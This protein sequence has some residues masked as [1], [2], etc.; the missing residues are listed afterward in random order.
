M[1]EETEDTLKKIICEVDS[2]KWKSQLIGGKIIKTC[3]YCGE[4]QMIDENS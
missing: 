3:E 1:F 2:H 4:T